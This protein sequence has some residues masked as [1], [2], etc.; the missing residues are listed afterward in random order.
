MDRVLK[1]KILEVEG[2]FFIFY[3]FCK[4]YKGND[5]NDEWF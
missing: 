2:F 4:F 3:V 1:Y 5:E